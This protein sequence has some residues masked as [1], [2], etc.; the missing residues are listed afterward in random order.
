M[1]M[2]LSDKIMDAGLSV[3]FGPLVLCEKLQ[4]GI[5]RFIATILALPLCL[6]CVLLSFPFL[7]V[8]TI[9][10]IWEKST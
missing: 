6:P 4:P 7:V 10:D 8:G 2:S 1:S 5:V 9:L 3:C